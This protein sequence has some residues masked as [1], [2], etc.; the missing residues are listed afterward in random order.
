MTTVIRVEG[1]GPAVISQVAPP[2]PEEST[3][4]R[5]TGATV[6]LDDAGFV[7]SLEKADKALAKRER[8]ATKL[9]S[10]DD[11]PFEELTEEEIE[12]EGRFAR[13]E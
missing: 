12:R 5:A 9:T 8:K 7:G 2:E 4:G 1:T 10:Q 3:A 11:K 13:E 6:V